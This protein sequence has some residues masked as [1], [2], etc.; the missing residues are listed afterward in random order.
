MKFYFRSAWNIT[1]PNDYGEYIM[2]KHETLP[3]Q[4]T[5]L[6]GFFRFFGFEKYNLKTTLTNIIHEI[7]G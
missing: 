4:V 1:S 6:L 5:M 3:Q 2:Y 7:N